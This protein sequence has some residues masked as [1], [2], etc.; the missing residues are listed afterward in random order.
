MSYRIKKLSIDETELIYREHLF[1]HFPAK[2]VKPLKHIRRMWNEGAYRALGF[3]DDDHLVG[4]AFFALGRNSSMV[5]L[6]YYAILEDYRGKGVGG[7]FLTSL[8]EHFQNFDGMLIE[9]EDV[10]FAQ[11]EEQV[12]ERVYRDGFY[13][14]KGVLATDITCEVYG[15]HYRVWQLPFKRSGCSTEQCLECLINI[16]KVMVPGEKYENNVRI[17]LRNQIV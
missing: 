13:E 11:N 8:W 2:E 1:R 17:R 12:R 10:D 7:K 15:V 3:Y 14:R 5:L 4:Y 9:T 6:D 16:Y